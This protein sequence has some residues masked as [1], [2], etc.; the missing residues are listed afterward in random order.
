MNADGPLLSANEGL[1]SSFGGMVR[2]GVESI[3]SA[4]YWAQVQP[5]ASFAD[6]PAARAIPAPPVFIFRS[7]TI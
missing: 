5:Y 7:K 3:R 6:V 1:N 2:A 4:F